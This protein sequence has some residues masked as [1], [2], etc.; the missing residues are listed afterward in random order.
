MRDQSLEIG[1]LH[2]AYAVGASAAGI[3]DLV[4]ARIAEADDP[5]IFL[6]VVPRETLLR[7]AEALGAFDPARPLWGVP[8]AVKD[9]ID[10]AGQPTTAACK[11]FSHVAD[12]DA[13]A[14]AALRRAGALVIGKT[15]LDQFA[16]GLVGVRTPYPVPRNPHDASRIPGGSSSGS[17][18][19]V[20]RGLVS[21]ALGTDTAGSGRVPAGL[22]GIVGL[23]PTLGLV[24]TSG[25]VPAC[26]SLDCVSVF[27]LTV[28]DA[29]TGL[30]AIAGFDPA[31]AYSRR[32]PAPALVPLSGPP[33]IG[34]P[35]AAG[36]RFFGDSAAA[37][38]FDAG[39]AQL[40]SLGADLVTLDFTPLFETAALLYEAA[41]V[42]ER[43]AAVADFLAR[44]PDA[45]LPVTAQIVGAADRLTAVDAFRGFYRLQ[46]LKRAA[47]PILASVDALAVPTVPRFWRLDEVAAD[48][49]ATNSTLGTYTNFVNLLDLCGL[50]VP[51]PARPDGLPGGLT[52]LAL[53]GRDGLLAP[54]GEALQRR[55]GA[56]LGATGWEPTRTLPA[57]PPDGDSITLA[58]VGAHLRGQPLNAELTSLGARFVGE[59]RTAPGYR[60]F[61]LDTAPP[62]PGLLRAAGGGAIAVELWRLDPAAF[63][64]FVAAIPA[65]LG[66]GSVALEDGTEARGFL[67]EAAGTTGARDITAFGG[68]RAWLGEAA[69][70]APRSATG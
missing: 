56:P 32:L 23:K 20:A 38:A 35:D 9:N 53:A 11:A 7:E 43:K 34:I 60:L 13:A 63:G 15:N 22:N 21:L 61:L 44:E 58:V 51:T 57:G 50:S 40:E 65:P 39:L 12:E 31:D 47:E 1:A 24:S 18:V 16:T 64:R 37:S 29:W 4:L 70:G 59:A 49:I 2:A 52:L 67:V 45:L 14:V 48:P 27:A 62:K 17:A 10:A 46:A 55:S 5:G 30:E 26:R 54:L 36:R 6:H 41:W 33:R 69:S 66:I 25:V 42:A 8:V 28:A 3:V 19:A 68:W